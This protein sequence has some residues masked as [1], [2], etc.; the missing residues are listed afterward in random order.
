MKQEERENRIKSRNRI[1]SGRTDKSDREDE[2]KEQ[3]VEEESN[4]RVVLAGHDAS[5][6][7]WK[8]G[9]F[10]E[11]EQNICVCC[12]AMAWMALFDLLICKKLAV[13]A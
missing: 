12:V 4:R 5:R 13:I 9:N 1:G 2:D 11:L 6:V 7:Q 8:T 10:S 3:K